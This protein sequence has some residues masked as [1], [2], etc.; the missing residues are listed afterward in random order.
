M[1]IKQI[2]IFVE[3]KPGRLADIT[4][5]LAKRDI[6][7][8]ALSIADTTDYGILRLIVSKPDKAV[9]VIREEGMTVSATNVLGIAIPDEPGGF[10][11][12]IAVL[13]DNE[14]SVEYAYAFITP[15]VGEAYIILRVADNDVAAD[16]LTKAGIR[17]IEQADIFD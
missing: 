3:N 9:E 17:L 6:D 7:I 15:R 13:A 12:A 5:I 14:I 1:P 16:V 11:K 2:S 4:A 8:R 10:A